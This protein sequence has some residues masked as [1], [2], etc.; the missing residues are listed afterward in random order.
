MVSVACLVHPCDSAPEHAEEKA[1][2]A[3]AA[4]Q[5][6]HGRLAPSAMDADVAADGESAFGVALS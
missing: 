4:V 6:C 2:S 5:L 1:V 3:A